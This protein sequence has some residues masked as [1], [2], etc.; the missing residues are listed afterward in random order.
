MKIN[1]D[2]IVKDTDPILRERSVDVLLPL[3]KEDKTLL[4]ELLDY[5]KKSTDPEIAEKENLRPAVGISAVQVGVLK[6]LNAMVVPVENKN[7]DYVDQ[8]YALANPKI[9][10]HS[11]EKA[12][13]K[14]GEGCLSVENNHPGYVERSARIKVRAFDVLQNREITLRLSGFLAIVFQHELDHN[15]G[16]LFYDRINKENPFAP[17]ANAIEIE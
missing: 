17:I 1:N 8:I 7:G 12:Y 11:L 15:D 14:T 13:L 10:S 4:L 5:V 3:N 6:K 9:I 2:T 16:I